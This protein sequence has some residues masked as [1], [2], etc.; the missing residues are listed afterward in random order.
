MLTINPGRHKA[1]HSSRLERWLGEEQVENVSRSMRDWYGP[2]IAM[3]GVPGA[4]YAGRDGDFAGDLRAGFEASKMDRLD[5]LVQRTK[6]GWRRS[7]HRAARRIQLNTGFA[8]LS[9]L[10]D[11]ATHGK[12]QELFFQKVGSTGVVNSANTLWDNGNLPSAGPAATAAPGGLALVNGNR[13]TFVFNNPG[14]SD[15]LHFVTGRITASVA[16][17]TLLLYDRLFGVAKTM[18]STATESVTGVPTR[19]QSS[20]PGAEDYAGGNFVFPAIRAALGATNHNWTVCQY[21]NQAG[22]DAQTIPSIAGLNAG[23]VDR[24]DL[25]AGYWFMPLAA[26]D[27]GIMDLHQLQC[28]ASV[29]GTLSFAI[30]HPIAFLPCPIANFVCTEDGI[31]SAFNLVRIF[32]DAA[33]ALLEMPK[34]ATTATTYS[35][36]I[37]IVAG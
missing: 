33:L 13:G 35:G 9:D 23:I 29:T 5:A 30:G 31:N 28:S 36:S 1:V 21:R 11:E 17:N 12:R 4:V 18:S 16:G 26:G 6:R 27:T 20:T 14:G 25:P 2:P 37:T 32:T 24:L 7:V 8:S 19:Y 10:I 3:S 22:T 15:T 34:P